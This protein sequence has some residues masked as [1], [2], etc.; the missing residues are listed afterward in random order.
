MTLLIPMPPSV[1]NLFL[2]VQGRGRVKSPHYRAWITEA[3]WELK[4]QKPP[5]FTGDFA[6]LIEAGPRNKRR[7]V[8]NLAKPILDLLVAM[9]VVQD[10]RYATSVTVAWNNDVQGCRV[11]IAPN[12]GALRA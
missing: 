10:D 4:M 8:D 7:D 6:I 2:N 3:G 5:R 9:K 1:N 11:K 12:E